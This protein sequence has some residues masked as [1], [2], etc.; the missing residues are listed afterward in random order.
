MI[1]LLSGHMNRHVLSTITVLPAAKSWGVSAV[2]S[3]STRPVN[4]HTL[5]VELVVIIFLR[6]M[7]LI[8]QNPL[9]LCGSIKGRQCYLRLACEY[10]ASDSNWGRDSAQPRNASEATSKQNLSDRARS[11]Y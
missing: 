7:G 11:E 10:S 5:G 9:T 8:C 2:D 6:D 1:L 3:E 4:A